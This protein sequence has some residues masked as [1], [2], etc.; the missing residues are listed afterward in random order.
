MIESFFMKKISVKEL[1]FQEQIK[2]LLE[3]IGEDLEREGIKETPLRVEK[4]FKFLLNGYDR[5]FKTENKLFT[6]TEYHEPIILKDI[7]FYSLCEHHLLPFY[8]YAHIAYI[9][10]GKVMGISKL[11]RVVDI[12]ARRLQ[13]QERMGTQ[14]A[15]ELMDVEG[16]KGVAV[17]LEARH[18]C[19][20][21]RGVEK[22]AST[23]S[24][25]V[26]RGD[27]AQSEE[28]KNRFMNLVAVRQNI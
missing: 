10:G 24:T 20:A 3:S 4:T 6:N 1:K 21:I 2:Q 13:D 17:L 15:S 27:F 9:P 26:Y 16:V 28:L 14:I 18:F 11:A 25:L 8:G 19:N 5:S 12:Y 7:D 22:K 23:M